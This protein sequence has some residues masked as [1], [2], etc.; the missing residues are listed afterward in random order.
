MFLQVVCYYFL[1]VYAVNSSISYST[2][3]MSIIVRQD[4]EFSLP[5]LCS[6]NRVD[7]QA[8]TGHSLQATLSQHLWP[9]VKQWRMNHGF[10]L[11]R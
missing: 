6:Q 7:K 1:L 5:E 4:S 8:D 10:L 9:P 2:K 11:G 3:F